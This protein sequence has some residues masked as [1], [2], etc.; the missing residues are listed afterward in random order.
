MAP[1]VHGGEAEEVDRHVP[2]R[3]LDFLPP[4]STTPCSRR[5]SIMS[6]SAVGLATIEEEIHTLE[7]RVSG[8]RTQSEIDELACTISTLRATRNTLIPFGRLSFDILTRVFDLVASSYY[9]CWTVT[10]AVS[11]ISRYRDPV[12]TWKELMAVCMF[13]RQVALQSLRLWSY[14]SLH[15]RPEWFRLCLDRAGA[16]RLSVISN[17]YSLRPLSNEEQRG[18]SRNTNLALLTERLATSQAVDS[19][20]SYPPAMLY[21][22]SLRGKLRPIERDGTLTAEMGLSLTSLYFCNLRLSLDMPNCPQLVQLVIH[23]C[24]FRGS[25]H[26]L[27]RHIAKIAPV[28]QDI[29]IGPIYAPED[30][31][32]APTVDQSEGLLPLLQR[33]DIETNYRTATE[34]LSV[35]ASPKS[36]LYIR[37]TDTEVEDDVQHYRDTMLAQMRRIAPPTADAS[38]ELQPCIWKDFFSDEIDGSSLYIKYQDSSSRI[39]CT[40]WQKSIKDWSS[41]FD[42]FSTVIIYGKMAQRFFSC[43]A[44][45][46]TAV[47]TSITH[48]II[49]DGEGGLVEL[50]SW[51]DARA[52]ADK[53]VTVVDFKRCK[54]YIQAH[55]KVKAFA[56]Q[57]I[58]EQARG[59]VRNNGKRVY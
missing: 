31:Q 35:F 32:Y 8:V 7:M 13:T 5:I 9:E 15:W 24:W 17:K 58:G 20:H 28:L 51:L 56:R 59:A 50:G 1:R 29:H 4:Q 36:K 39:T 30:E 34:V 49:R 22:L 33:I 40:L 43:A 54:R 6:A 18:A 23:A 21:C 44:A 47:F 42:H 2:R 27:F 14:L 45:N 19:S 57:F 46:A 52:A 25:K 16:W 48:V 3:T 37:I 53:P 55:G 38:L 41:V 26:E 10:N 11:K 12:I